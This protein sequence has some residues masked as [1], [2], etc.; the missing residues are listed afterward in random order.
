MSPHTGHFINFVTNSIEPDNYTGFYISDCMIHHKG[1]QL[2]AS[3]GSTTLNNIEKK[4]TNPAN[5]EIILDSI[6]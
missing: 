2:G 4:I 5:K 1:G 6:T 3:E